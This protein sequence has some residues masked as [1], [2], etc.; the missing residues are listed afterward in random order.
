M[1][2]YHGCSKDKSMVTIRGMDVSQGT[3]LESVVKGALVVEAVAA[4]AGVVEAMNRGLVI[5]ETSARDA[6][7]SDIPTKEDMGAAAI[8]VRFVM[9]EILHEVMA[10]EGVKGRLADDVRAKVAVDSVAV[11][12]EEES[13]MAFNVVI[14]MGP[15][16]NQQEDADVNRL[17]TT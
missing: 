13:I 8:S 11:D 12:E 15:T 7:I 6:N 14:Q 1:M 4:S 10:D 17:T 5:Q 3:L 16:M 9:R 2:I